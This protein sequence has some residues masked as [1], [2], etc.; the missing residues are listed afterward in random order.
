MEEIVKVKNASYARYEELLIRRDVLRKEAYHYQMA[1]IREFG[2]LMTQAFEAKIKCIEKK[3]IIAYCQKKK[4]RGET[5]NQNDINQ[6]IESVM[7]DYYSQLHNLLDQNKNLKKGEVVSELTFRKI[8]AAYYKIA[9]LIH[10]DMNPSLKEDETVKDLWNRAV[11]A[12]DCN[13]L[14]ELEE[15]LVL[16]NKYLES[17]NYQHGEID[18]PDINEKIFELNEEIDTIIHTDPYQYKYLLDDPDAVAEIKEDLNQ[19]IEDYRKYA[20]ELDEVINSFK[21]ERYAA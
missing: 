1:Y 19:Q 17:I 2:D 12:Y 16:V 21:I 20:S 14:K 5:I 13:N 9:K 8:K 18:I 11:I 15:L 7:G 4:N 3:K 10:P 6:Y